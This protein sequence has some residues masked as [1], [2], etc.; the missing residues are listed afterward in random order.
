MR[1]N[2]LAF[3]IDNGLGKSVRVD[4]SRE[5]LGGIVILAFVVSD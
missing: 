4:A 3:P 1:V 5:E 2:P